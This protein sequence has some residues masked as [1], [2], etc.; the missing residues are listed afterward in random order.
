VTPDFHP[1]GAGGGGDGSTSEP[2]QD[3]LAGGELPS[4]D[5]YVGY[6]AYEGGAMIEYA[7]FGDPDWD[8]RTTKDVLDD[9]NDFVEDDLDAAGCTCEHVKVAVFRTDT[10]T[11]EERMSPGGGSISNK[12]SS[13]FFYW[14]SDDDCPANEHL[15]S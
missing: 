2:W 7:L 12:R 6:V 13:S 11:P 8:H 9:W 1:F 5:F 15:T 4:R 3:W 10:R 14:H